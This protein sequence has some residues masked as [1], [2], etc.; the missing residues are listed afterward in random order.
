M[1]MERK[2]GGVRGGSKKREGRV[3][4]EREGEGGRGEEE[5]EEQQQPHFHL[6]ARS[7]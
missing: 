4:P 7:P 5:D 6:T 2:G 3:V 1:T